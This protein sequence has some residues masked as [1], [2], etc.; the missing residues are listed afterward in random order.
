MDIQ[1][2]SNFERLLFELYGRR[3]ETVADM[4]TTFR[5]QGSI[6]LEPHRLGV[7][8]ERWD[9]VCIDDAAT[10]AVIAEVHGST[11]MVIDP[12]TAV[13]VGAARSAHRS[14]SPTVT[15]ATAHPAKFPDAVEEAIGIRPELPVHLAD[16]FERKERFDR[17]PN[18]LAAVQAHVSERSRVTTT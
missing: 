14:G 3:G 17:L 10:A 2:S 8:R 11:G 12:H 13:G 7:L 15:L 16:L 18:D 6:E 9:G 4:L 1:V 5:D